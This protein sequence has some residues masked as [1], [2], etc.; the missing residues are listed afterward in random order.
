M[1]GGGEM[2]TAAEAATLEA[3]FAADTAGHTPNQQAA[4]CSGGG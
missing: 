2:D 1:D 4:A 3:G